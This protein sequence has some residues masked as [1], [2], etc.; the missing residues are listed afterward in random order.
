MVDAVA[1]LVDA[2]KVQLFCVD[3]SDSESWHAHG[4][5]REGIQKA[6]SSL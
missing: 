4:A 6:L 3:T 1:D 2:G 5:L